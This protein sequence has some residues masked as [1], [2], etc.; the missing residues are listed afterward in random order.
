MTS[1]EWAMFAVGC[2]VGAWSL[3]RNRTN[4]ARAMTSLLFWGG[5]VVYATSGSWLW[6]L[7]GSLLMAL[8]LAVRG[9]LWLT[10]RK[11]MAPT[12]ELVAELKARSPELGAMA[13]ASIK[14]SVREAMKPKPPQPPPA[15]PGPAPPIHDPNSMPSTWFEEPPELDPTGIPRAQ[16]IHGSV[17]VPRAVTY[18]TTRGTELRISPDFIEVKF[19]LSLAEPR[20]REVDDVMFETRVA[21]RDG[22]VWR[23]RSFM[24][25]DSLVV[26]RR[27]EPFVRWACAPEPW[28]RALSENCVLSGLRGLLDGR[29]RYELRLFDP[30]PSGDPEVYVIHEKYQGPTVDV[31]VVPDSQNLL[32]R[33]SDLNHEVYSRAED[34][35]VSRWTDL[36]VLPPYAYELPASDVFPWASSPHTAGRMDWF[37][38]PSDNP[39]TFEPREERDTPQPNVIEIDTAARP[40]GE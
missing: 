16:W 14:R 13:E 23:C 5:L 11:A 10:L 17:E 2:A 31:G 27:V 15:P 32:I 9:H 36:G 3:F 38:E 25:I 37:N 26:T 18:P 7:P 28:R 8:A 40:D 12:M 4:F 20:D 22:R 29:D 33:V 6:L 1:I 19:G 35:R 21:D 30:E 39:L 34:W 24:R